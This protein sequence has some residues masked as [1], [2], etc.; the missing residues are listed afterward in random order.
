M[1]RSMKTVAFGKEARTKLVEGVNILA[2]AVRVT[3]GPKGRNVVI[4]KRSG[5]PVIT[6]DGVSVAREVN[7]EDYYQDMGVQMVKDVA[8]QAVA[9]AG[10]GTTTATVIA[11]ALINE[12]VRA[13]ETG[14][15]P[16][17][18][19]T[20]IELVVNA[21]NK[22]LTELSRP[23]Q[24]R[25]E[26]KSIALIST[27]GDEHL[28]EM[29]TE[30]VYN[31]GV[32]GV[33]KLNPKVS[34][35]DSVAFEEGY[36]FDRGWH[37]PVYANVQAT[38]ETDYTDANII[39]FRG[40][41]DKM[42]DGIV[43]IIEEHFKR[44]IP[45][46]IMAEDFDEDFHK[47]AASF[48]HRERVKMVLIRSPFFGNHRT[49]AQDDLA[50]LLGTRVVE[51]T[52]DV[53]KDGALSEYIGQVGRVTATRSRTLLSGFPDT[54]DA[55]AKRVAQ[56]RE[57]MSNPEASGIERE[58]LAERAAKLESR[59][60]A[61][62]LHGDTEIEWKEKYDRADD[63][64]CATR[65]AM[66]EGYVAGG[67]ATLLRIA[68]ELNGKVMGA[69]TDQNI[70]ISTA[71][72]AMESPIRQIAKNAA[73]EDAIVVY[74]VTHEATGDNYGYNARTGEFGDV[75]EMGIVDP[76]K[77]TRSALTNAA[78][79]AGLFITIECAIGIENDLIRA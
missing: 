18:V 46:I 79:V 40:D 5:Q 14:I 72:R 50:L 12:G 67:G 27:N 17:D 6:K 71:L 38:T 58:R 56:L 57:Q 4:G 39:I 42:T 19:K 2:D 7:L 25:E 47:A 70:G 78:S 65:A 62:N 24:T 61:I 13:V 29:V 11:Q 37:N 59:V 48:V 30:A 34:H 45:L 20:G 43:T 68:H 16:L 26:V 77:V 63:A 52:Y 74:K 36:Y 21:A 75:I 60:A 33:V 31:T 53:S 10:D 69:N 54:G 41:L 51:T 32:D 35:E 1:S 22:R 55:I 76:V 28:A 66:E 64:I 73:V 9:V 3:L 15:N 49:G 8:Q 44:D 23:C